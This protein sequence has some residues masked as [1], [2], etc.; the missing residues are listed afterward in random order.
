MS[1]VRDVQSQ[2]VQFDTKMARLLTQART[3]IRNATTWEAC[4]DAYSD[5]GYG[6]TEATMELN[7]ELKKITATIPETH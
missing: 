2:W 7:R 3:T 4:F 6:A 1:V 5:F